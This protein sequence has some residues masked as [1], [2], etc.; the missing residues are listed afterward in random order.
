MKNYKNNFFSRK[1]HFANC[2][3]IRQQLLS[4][5]GFGHIHLCKIG[6]TKWLVFMK[7]NT[8]FN[9]LSFFVFG[10]FIISQNKSIFVTLLTWV[11]CILT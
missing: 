11:N 9:V 3:L 5:P 8:F 10:N 2:L 4:D 1:G 6:C 7:K